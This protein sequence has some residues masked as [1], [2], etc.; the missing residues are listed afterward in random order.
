MGREHCVVGLNDGSRNLRAGVEGK[1]ELALLPVVDRQ[2]LHEQGAE[3]RA[4]ATAEAVEDDEALEASAVV[5]KLANAVKDEI[6]DLLADG[7]VATRIVVGGVLLARDQLL[8]VEELAVGSAPHLVNDG[9]FEVDEDAPGSGLFCVS[10]A[11]RTIQNV[12]GVTADRSAE[13]K[14]N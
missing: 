4:R 9:G 6:N 5:R 3:A 12:R 7:V 10:I 1:L 14:A 11:T 13:K 2:T 8:G